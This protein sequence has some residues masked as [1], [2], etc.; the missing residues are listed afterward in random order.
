M[1]PASSQAE[2]ELSIVTS[3]LRPLQ[4]DLLFVFALLFDDDAGG[5]PAELQPSLNQLR[6][7]TGMHRASVKRHLNALEQEKRI[8]RDRPSR[9]DARRYHYRTRYTVLVPD[10]LGAECALAGRSGHQGLGAGSAGLGAAS[11]LARRRQRQKLGAAGA[12]HDDDDQ[13]SSP[14]WE[15]GDI[16]EVARAELARSTSRSI[17]ADQAAGAVRMILEGREVSRPIPYLRRAIR[18]DPGRYLPASPPGAR[19]FCLHCGSD[20]HMIGNC[21]IRGEP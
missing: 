17:T 16:V 10:G 4:R 3:D 14:A 18:E 12:P 1:Q 15:D 20:R 13:S 2:I 19:L 7:W 21:P 8:V 5:I 6:D 11:T 9:A